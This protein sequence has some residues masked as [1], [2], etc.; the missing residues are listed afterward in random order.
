MRYW[1]I[2]F[3]CIASVSTHTKLLGQNRKGSFVFETSAIMLTP[4]KTEYHLHHEKQFADDVYYDLIVSPKQSWGVTLSAGYSIYL[5][6]IKN[7]K[8]YLPLSASYK[9]IQESNYQVGEYDGGFAN[10]YFNGKRESTYYY[11][12]FA[13]NTGLNVAY[14]TY[15]DNELS[16]EALFSCNMNIA[17]RSSVNYTFHDFEL[18]PLIHFK[19]AYLF[20]INKTL[21][22]PFVTYSLNFGTMPNP[23]ASV[24]NIN[25]YNLFELGLKLKI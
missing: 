7:L 17:T 15:K 1:Y 24:N 18:L 21:L 10:V 22:G 3:I 11:T 8:I 12:F 20:K 6:N 25:Y 9:Y 5:G 2:I 4:N 19:G 14:K 16:V 13:L 23:G